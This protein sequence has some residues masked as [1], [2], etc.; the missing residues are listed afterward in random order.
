MRL[1][2]FV[3][4]DGSPRAGA[5][6]GPTVIDLAVAA[7][8]VFEDT[9]DLRWDLLSVLQADQD[10][11]S[12]DGAAEIV[13]AVTQIVGG[14]PPEPALDR[15]GAR[16]DGL[17]GGL[18][19]GGANMILPLDQVRLLAPLPRPASLR[20]FYT[21]EQHVATARRQCGQD[22]P[23]EWYRFPAFYFSNHGAIYGPDAAVP[24]PR[25]EALDY[26]LELACVIGRAGRDI[27]VEEAAD[28]I[29]GYMIMNDWSARDLQADERSIGLGP[30]KAKDFATS[31][32][33][34]L[35][36]PD[37]LEI[38]A[39][40]DG[41]LSL[42]ML[43]R[44]NAVERSRGSA[45]SM[46]YSFAELIAHASRDATLY[47]GDVLGSGT[48]GGGC[49]LELTDGYGPWLERGDLVELEITG[50]GVLRNTIV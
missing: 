28:Y 1:V 4:P 42:T 38:Y 25:T 12:L 3:P 21:F 31:L 2:T 8:L 49:L 16:D 35:V 34:W 17:A 19:I 41:R 10:L 32:G 36:T 9:E 5:L 22:V 48:V 30:A 15:N 20:D 26:E 14:P 11:V 24:M 50:L 45:A 37:E 23:A 43:A 18:S 33:P 39:G 29:A 6:L 40:E 46:Y 47:P 7:P 44:V 13:A 27:A